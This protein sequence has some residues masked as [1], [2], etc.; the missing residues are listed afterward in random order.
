ME[1]AAFHVCLI[2]AAMV[3]VLAIPVVV[4]TV[5]VLLEH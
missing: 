3:V 4:G 1:Y 5:A 2:G